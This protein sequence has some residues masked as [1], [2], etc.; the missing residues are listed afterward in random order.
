MLGA[1]IAA[2]PEL[3]VGKPLFFVDFHSANYLIVVNCASFQPS[4]PSA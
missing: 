3:K 1:V 4:M 2:A